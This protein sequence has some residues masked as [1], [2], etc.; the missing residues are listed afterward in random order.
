M[1]NECQHIASG[2]C[3]QYFY[4]LKVSN[5]VILEFAKLPGRICMCC[6]R[7]SEIFY[8]CWGIFGISILFSA[9]YG[10]DNIGNLVI[11]QHYREDLEI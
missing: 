8:Y 5:K 1:V 10:C 3:A 2:T 9:I 7:G 4:N 11:S 6:C